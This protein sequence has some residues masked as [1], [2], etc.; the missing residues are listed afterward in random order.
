MKKIPLLDLQAQLQTIHGEIREAVDHVLDSG[1]YIMG[2]EVKAF[3]EE[4]AKYVG[5]KHAIGVANGTDAL[6]LALDA[7]GIGPGDEVITTTFT[8]FATAETVSQLGATPVFVDI[9]PKTY[10]IDVE[11]VKQKINEKT[12]AIIPVHIFGQPANMDELMALA[13]EHGLFVLEDAAQAMGSEYKGKKIGSLGHAATYS[14]FPTKNLGGYG[15]GGMVVTND[16]ELARK[17]RILRVHGSNPKYYHSMIGYNSRL[18]AL[19]AAMLRVKLRYL[20]QWNH[21]R[22]QKAALYN[23]LLKD[24]PVVTP[25]A[26]EDLKHIYHLYIIQADDREELMEYLKEHGIST[27]V[28]YP[29]PLHQQNVY[30]PLG[31]KEGSLPTSEYMAKRTF[32]LPL[33]AELE[34]ETIHF[35]VDTIKS[36]YANK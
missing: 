31:Y 21:G 26:E 18:D 28:Y 34:D 11:Q 32:A 12:K 20:D 4:V 14:F 6:L 1:I 3:E 30:Q 8:F 10:N 29:V 24:T 13:K 19:Q 5:V 33:Y 9:D 17:I 7:A 27:G 35:I 36:Y 22:R 15:D 23:E 25:Y 16:D 2:P